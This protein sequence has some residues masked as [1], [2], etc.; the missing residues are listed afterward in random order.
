MSARRA[1]CSPG[2]FWYLVK[3]LLRARTAREASAHSSAAG[4]L[5]QLAVSGAM[6]VIRFVVMG[7]LEPEVGVAAA[8]GA[9]TGDAER[10]GSLLQAGAAE[11][12]R[13]RAAV[14]KTGVWKYMLLCFD[15]LILVRD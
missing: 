14:R 15:V 2:V 12:P 5:A 11:A 10:V 4:A 1:A 13:A 8:D 9:A 6:L 7:V 3:A